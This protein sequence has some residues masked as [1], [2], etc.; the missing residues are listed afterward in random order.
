MCICIYCRVDDGLV[1]SVCPVGL[2]RFR[3]QAISEENADLFQEQPGIH[4]TFRLPALRVPAVS[5]PVSA[6]L[7]RPMG[8]PLLIVARPQHSRC[9]AEVEDRISVSV[10]SFWFD[11]E[12]S[13]V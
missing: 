4:I 12:F 2:L 7:W 1:F 13:V 5:M 10:C 11:G 3:L 6:L 9:A 8:I